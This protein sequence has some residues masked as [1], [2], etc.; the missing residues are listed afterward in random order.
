MERE[1]GCPGS[2]GGETSFAFPGLSAPPLGRWISL[3][4][5]QSKHAESSPEKR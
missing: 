2:S 1:R 4:F 3:L 5:G